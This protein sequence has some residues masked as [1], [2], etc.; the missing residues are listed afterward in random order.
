ME[1]RE[2]FSIN[3]GGKLLFFSM[4][5]CVFGVLA[6]VL[7]P[8]GTMLAPPAPPPAEGAA[9]APGLIGAF[10][11]G[12]G[13]IVAALIFAVLAGLLLGYGKSRHPDA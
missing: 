10:I 11:P 4:I 3:V 12:I 13:V 5:L 2:P 1:G 9:P 7:L 6:L 8:L